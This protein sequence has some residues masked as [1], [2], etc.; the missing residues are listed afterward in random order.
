MIARLRSERG[1]T[2]V[3]FAGLAVFALA[4][5]LWQGAA[6]RGGGATWLDS[7]VCGVSRPLQ[8]ILTSCADFVE[9]EWLATVHARDLIDENADLSA[10]VAMLEAT[11]SRSDEERA[12]YG[13]EAA[14]R[15]AYPGV[16]RDRL[17]QVIGVGE[18]GWFNH[19]T[20]DR[21][22]AHGV[23]VRDVAVTPEG[24]I[25]Q[26]SAVA[27]RTCRLVPLTEPA[28]S[29]AVR[30]QRS[31]DGGLLEGLGGWRC[32]LRYLSPNADV[33]PGDVVLTSGLGGVF[34]PGLRVG[35]ITSVKTDPAAPGKAAE[36]RPAARLRKVEDVLLLPARPD[37][38]PEP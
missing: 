16:G 1:R 13:R 28:S 9:R 8:Q 29:V 34:P 27:A 21:G 31:R 4:L 24:L 36:V 22:S 20:L 12:A 18:G 11:L 33:Q 25:G 38:W 23:R 32:E 15:S 6:R 7:A 5:H 14:L 10:R 3:L 17:A 30:L 35:I 37:V 19:L 2:A 26:V